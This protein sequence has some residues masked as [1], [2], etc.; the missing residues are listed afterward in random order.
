MTSKSKVALACLVIQNAGLYLAMKYSFRDGAKEYS[1]ASVVLVS[2]LLKLV[3]CTFLEFLSLQNSPQLL[4]KSTRI[5]RSNMFMIVPAGFY[6]LQNILQMV[7]VEAYRLPLISQ[8]SLKVV[9]SA[10]SL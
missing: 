1:Q 9:S 3:S 6:V 2:E 5:S 4:S 7:A 10:F 8:G